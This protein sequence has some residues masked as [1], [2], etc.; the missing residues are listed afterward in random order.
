LLEF[1]LFVVSTN[2][3]LLLVGGIFGFMIPCIDSN[4]YSTQNITKQP[5]AVY[6]C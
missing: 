4:L 2:S 3:G 1:R 5:F 6:L